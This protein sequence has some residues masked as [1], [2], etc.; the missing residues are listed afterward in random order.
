MAIIW[1]QERITVTIKGLV[2]PAVWTEEVV[3]RN[4]KPGK[5][6]ELTEIRGISV[7]HG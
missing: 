3:V 7:E 5:R 4:G 1:T 2:L 6:V